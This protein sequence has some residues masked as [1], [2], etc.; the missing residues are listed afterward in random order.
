M[1]E[2]PRALIDKSASFLAELN[3]KRD[4]IL[5]ILDN[6]ETLARTPSVEAELA[7]VLRQIATKLGRLLMTSRRLERLEARPIQVLPM[8]EETGSSLLRRLGEAYGANPLIK[9]GEATLKK[10]CRRLSGKPLLID[11]LARHIGM[12]G[13]NIDQGVRA[14]L[15][16]GSS[17]LGE[18]LFED[19]WNCMSEPQKQVFLLVG[20]LGGA[21][22]GQAV[23][24]ACAD[25]GV[26]FSDWL[27]AFD[28]TRFGSINDYGPVFD[29]VFQQGAR[30]FLSKKY[31]DLDGDEKKTLDNLTYSIRKRY[32]QLLRAESTSISDRV[33]TAF[34]TSA[35]KAAK[36]AA[37]RGD[38]EEALIWY[39]EAVSN[40]PGN[41]ALLDR[42]AW[43][44]M[45]NRNL[46]RAWSVALRACQTD[47]KDADAHFTAGM[48]AGRRGNVGEADR[49]LDLARDLGKKNHLC[50]L[51]KARARIEK[52]KEEKA[53]HNR[54]TS[55][56]EANDLLQEADLGNPK[57]FR[58]MKHQKERERLL[59]TTRQMAI[60]KGK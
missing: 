24:W 15:R 37:N 50:L 45:V 17:D 11:V 12:S 33:V 47:P 39:E 34:R 38:V 5:I 22:A 9:A 27:N 13:C 19:A 58:D 52:A 57:D 48:V 55:L 56:K 25:I 18:F 3:L 60:P 46:E 51:Q 30:D 28:E 21:I 32:E 41:A 4:D 20:Q 43:F 23:A 44:L 26:F 29:V 14:V 42:F 54:T 16:H 31:S 2:D 53:S 7:K 1:R 36:I 10:T 59:A 35:A 6:T 49:L 8:N 40:D